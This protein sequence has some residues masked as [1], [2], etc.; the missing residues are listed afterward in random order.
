MR[1]IIKKQKRTSSILLFFQEK[2]CWKVFHSHRGGTQVQALALLI[3]IRRNFI[4]VVCN[5]A[6]CCIWIKINK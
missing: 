1:F 5:Y 4:L 6:Y 2:G 3:E